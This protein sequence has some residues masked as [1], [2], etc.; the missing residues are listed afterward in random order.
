M[1]HFNEQPRPLTPFPRYVSSALIVFT[2]HYVVSWFYLLVFSECL[3]FAAWSA[4]VYLELFPETMSIIPM[5]AVSIP[6]TARLMAYF[7]YPYVEDYASF[8]PGI[9]FVVVLLLAF[10]AHMG[11][12]FQFL[13]DDINKRESLPFF[14]EGSLFWKFLKDGVIIAFYPVFGEV[15]FFYLLSQDLQKELTDQ[16]HQSPLQDHLGD[17]IDFDEPEQDEE[18]SSDV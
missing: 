13:I 15:I 14:S 6:F 5:F 11:G 10:V 7:R 3:Y 17:M 8:I 9:L 16:N 12:E 2:Y 18:K 1:I 4:G